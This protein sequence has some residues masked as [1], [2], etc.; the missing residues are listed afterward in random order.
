[1][2]AFAAFD[3]VG[4]FVFTYRSFVLIAHNKLLAGKLSR[5]DAAGIGLIMMYQMPLAMLAVQAQSVVRGDGT[6]SEKDMVGRAVGQMGGLGLFSEPWRWASGESN[7]FGSPGLIA[8][9]R[10]I[11]GASALMQGNVGTAAQ[12]A[13]TMIPVLATNPIWNRMTEETLKE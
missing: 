4:K 2:P 10:A 12:T 9:D 7:S 6:M 13:T 11:K 3:N 8:A 1:V 5:N